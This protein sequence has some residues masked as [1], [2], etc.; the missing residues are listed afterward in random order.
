M[1]GTTQVTISNQCNEDKLVWN[2]ITSGV[3]SMKDAY[4]FKKTN[5]PKVSWAKLIWYSDI[6]PSKSLLVWRLMLDK[7]PTEDILSGRSCHLPSICS[8][9]NSCA[10]TSFHLFFHCVYALN[11]SRWLASN[12]NCTFNFQTKVQQFLVCKESI[13]ILKQKNSLENLFCFYCF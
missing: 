12:T 6:P 10:K 8:L 4:K 3:F 7:L 9:C 13:K 11:H 2:H 5:F 1:L